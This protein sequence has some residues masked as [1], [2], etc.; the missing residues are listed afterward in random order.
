[1]TRPSVITGYCTARAA[2]KSTWERKKIANVS[3]NVSLSTGNLINVFSNYSTMSAEEQKT[4][5]VDV[6]ILGIFT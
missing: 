4:K 1:M 5:K 6:Q 3:L 2:E